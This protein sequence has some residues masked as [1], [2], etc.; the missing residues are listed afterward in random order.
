MI[1]TD[2][3]LSAVDSIAEEF[4]PEVVR[5]RSYVDP[6]SFGEPVVVANVVTSD[7]VTKDNVIALRER[8]RDRFNQVFGLKKLGLWPLFFFLTVTQQKKYNDPKWLELKSC[9]NNL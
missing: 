6:G 1:D 8:L 5:I 7:D 2:V 9:W 4:A 3:D